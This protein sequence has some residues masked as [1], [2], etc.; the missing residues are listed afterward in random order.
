MR[1]FIALLNLSLF[2]CLLASSS[3]KAQ[4]ANE[5]KTSPPLID[6]DF[7]PPLE[8]FYL[9]T[10]LNILAQDFQDSVLREYLGQHERRAT[11]FSTAIHYGL[12][13]KIELGAQFNFALSDNEQIRYGRISSFNGQVHEEKKSGLSN[14]LFFSR[15]RLFPEEE[16]GL[17]IDIESSIRPKILNSTNPA[18]NASGNNAEGGHLLA[19]GLDLFKSFPKFQFHLQG[20]LQWETTGESKD[21]QTSIVTTTDSYQVYILEFE[22]QYL[23][24]PL[25]SI[26]SIF[27]FDMTSSYIEREINSGTYIDFG[28]TSHYRFELGAR[29]EILPGSLLLD[30]AFHFDYSSYGDMNNQNRTII[31]RDEDGSYGLKL[32]ASYLF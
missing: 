21:A 16:L 7:F 9:E 8:Q 28:S 2:T 22:A 1:K 12:Y 5:D 6:L 20:I 3:L 24:Q 23:Y 18:A 4:E 11:I 13:E 17:G 19:F 14:P 31:N 10:S 15:Y 25:V 30:G 26:Y 27:H 29:Y 32:G